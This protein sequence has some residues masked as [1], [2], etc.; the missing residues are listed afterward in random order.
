MPTSRKDDPRISISAINAGNIFWPGIDPGMYRLADEDI[1]PQVLP[2]PVDVDAV[3]VSTGVEH[4]HHLTD[5]M[6]RHERFRT[7]SAGIVFRSLIVAAEDIHIKGSIV[8]VK[9]KF[10]VNGPS[11]LRI[12]NRLSRARSAK[13]VRK[14]ADIVASFAERHRTN[15]MD[16]PFADPSDRDRDLIVV[17]KNLFN[18]YHFTRE[19]M[20]LL[21]LYQDYNLTGRIIIHAQNGTAA[22]FVRDEIDRFFPELAE[23]VVL[24][25]GELRS[26]RALLPLDARLLYYQVSDDC[27]PSFHALTKKSW[28]WEDRTLGERNLKTLGMNSCETA[29]IALRER[30]LQR[31]AATRSPADVPARPRRLYVAR[32]PGR[33]PRAVGQEELLIAALTALDFEVIHFE[34]HDV[35]TQARLVSE[36]EVIVTAHGAGLTNM[37]YAPPGCLVVEISTLQ[38]AMLRFGDFSPLALVSRARYLHFFTDHDWPDQESIP[39]YDLHSLVGSQLDAAGIGI[40]RSLVI[41]HLDPLRHAQT[42]AAAAQLNTEGPGDALADFLAQHFDTMLHEPDA[43]VWAANCAA[44]RSRPKEAL[45]HLMQAAR[46]APQRR[47]LLERAILLAHR[48]KASGDFAS[49]AFGYFRYHR[50]FAVAFFAKRKWD[51]DPYVAT[52]DPDITP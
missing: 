46:L 21:T 40:L 24:S 31:V 6:T 39:D 19:T 50:E 25:T 47:A 41:A 3:I 37:L 36:A 27:M 5:Y 18:F 32:R 17:A 12:I 30:V 13:R 49:L 20:P 33:R 23:R 43:H 48:L 28:M 42:M 34:D 38:I 45:Q 35:L 4:R 51:A 15:R 52:P 16:L 1:A 14:L 8:T 22:A 11:G 10:L 2:C 44:S 9:G 26:P 7:F 29:L